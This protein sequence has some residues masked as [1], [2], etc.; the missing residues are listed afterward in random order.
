MVVGDAFCATTHSDL[1][2]RAAKL[3]IEVKVIH[4]ASII[5]A[6]G[7]C[8]LQVYRFGEVVSVPLWTEKWRPDSWYQK[9]LQNRRAGLHTLVLVDI[10]V[11][12]RTEE[13]IL[14]DRK[15]YEPPRFMTIKECVEQLLEAEAARGEEAYAPHTRCFGLARV[16]AAD[17]LI[18]AGTLGSF[19]ETDMGPPLHSFVL[20]AEKLHHM[21]EEMYQFFMKK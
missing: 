4:N 7:C 6:V 2:L 19:I 11:K 14:K 16:G 10:K 1:F 15:I 8:G 17:Q 12:E 5:S 18:R 3:S 20:C 21:E 13:N 9:I